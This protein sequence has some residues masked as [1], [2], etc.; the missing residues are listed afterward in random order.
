MEA[1]YLSQILGPN[2][3]KAVNTMLE[4]IHSEAKYDVREGWSCLGSLFT[5]T[6]L[7][8]ILFGQVIHP[9]LISCFVRRRYSRFLLKNRTIIRTDNSN[10]THK[11]KTVNCCV[12][13]NL[14]IE[15]YTVTN[16][17]NIVSVNFTDFSVSYVAFSKKQK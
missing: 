10:E 6:R 15:S 8:W 12:L 4:A 11:V 7:H 13:N 14:Y 17:E 3:H 2:S 1:Q 9:S 16:P 5:L